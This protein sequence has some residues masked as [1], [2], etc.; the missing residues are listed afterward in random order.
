MA[1]VDYSDLLKKKIG[2][3][4]KRKV[5]FTKELDKLSKKF[6]VNLELIAASLHIVSVEEMEARKSNEKAAT[7]KEDLTKKEK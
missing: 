1:N 6:G 2:E 3:I 7:K 4:E 5:E